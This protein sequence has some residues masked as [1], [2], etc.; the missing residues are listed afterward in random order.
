[1]TSYKL[2][3]NG[4]TIKA[5]QLVTITTAHGH[6]LDESKEYFNGATDYEN[7]IV[8]FQENGETI[9]LKL[10]V[11]K[12][13]FSGGLVVRDKKYG[14]NFNRVQNRRNRWGLTVWSEFLKQEKA[15]G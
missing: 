13:G 11:T 6:T 4:N 10:K 14:C 5:G 12:K 9:T 2:I 3:E 15:A 7:P 1:M 8:L